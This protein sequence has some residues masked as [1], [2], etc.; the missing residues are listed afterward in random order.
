MTVVCN[1]KYPMPLHYIGPWILGLN[2]YCNEHM[3]FRRKIKILQVIC[4][5]LWYKYSVFVAGITRGNEG[6]GPGDINYWRDKLF[7]NFITWLLPVCLVPL[8]P[9]VIVGIKAGY[10]LIATVDLIAATIV[11]A[12]GLYPK[13]NLTLRKFLI[14]FIL[15]CLAAFLMIFLGLLG[16]GFIYLLALSV[17]V[18]LT[19]PGKYAYYTVAINFLLSLCCALI[20]YFRLFNSPLINE[21]NL[22]A[23]IAVSSNLIFLSLVCVVLIINIFKG[24]ED[25]ISK[26]HGLK[27]QL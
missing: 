22:G 6:S 5:L 1:N 15:Y 16:P 24:L 10:P 11:F 4:K 17:F 19:F 3:G 25:T 7:T 18:T 14:A 20:I 12:I 8:V 9:G 23:W 27:K 2:R 26:E 21:F 13:L